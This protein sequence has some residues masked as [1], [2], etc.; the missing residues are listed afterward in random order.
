MDRAICLGDIVTE[1]VRRLL[2]NRNFISGALAVGSTTTKVNLASAVD[3]SID[4]QLYHKAITADT[5]AHTNL[6]VQSADSTKYYLLSLDSAGT[7][8]ITP[9]NEVLTVNIGVGGGVVQPYLPK[10]AST[11]T[12]IGVIKVVT[13][14]VT[15]AP[16]VDAHTKAGVT[17]TYFNLSCVPTSGL[18]V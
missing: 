7:G 4:G 15:F 8:L 3:Y 18:P 17:T 6:G 11:Q 13:V 10:L 14:A 1:E 2:G 9:G 5:F 16:G 12:P